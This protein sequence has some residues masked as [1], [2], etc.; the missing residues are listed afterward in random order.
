MVLIRDERG[1]F[2]LLQGRSREKSLGGGEAGQGKRTFFGI[3][4][5]GAGQEQKCKMCRWGGGGGA[6]AGQNNE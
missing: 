4:R 5:D 3:G 2:F 6:V 1:N